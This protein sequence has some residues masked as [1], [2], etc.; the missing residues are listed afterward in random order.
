MSS[1][2]YNSGYANGANDKQATNRYKEVVVGF[3]VQGGALSGSWLLKSDGSISSVGGNGM[4][5]GSWLKLNINGNGPQSISALRDGYYVTS[6]N[7]N[8]TYYSAGTTLISINDT[9]SKAFAAAVD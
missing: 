5:S 7:Y 2:S 6:N 1:A 4:M 8:R 3:V 9:V